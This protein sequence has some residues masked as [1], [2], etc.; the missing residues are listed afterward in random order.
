MLHPSHWARSLESARDAD[1]PII[2][3]GFSIWEETYRILEQ[4]ISSTGP[5]SPPTNCSVKKKCKWYFKV[6]RVNPNKYKDICC[7]SKK[8]DFPFELFMLNRVNFL[9]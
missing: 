4:T 8:K 3:I 7:S 2:R 9:H 1:N 5:F 6:D